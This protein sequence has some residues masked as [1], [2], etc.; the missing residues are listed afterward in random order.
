M[1]IP[2]CIIEE[3]PQME[4]SELEKY[5]SRVWN[6]LKEMKPGDDLDIGKV[7]KPET[8]ELFVE[9]CKHYMR[10]HEWQDGLTFRKGFVSL[11]KVAIH[12]SKTS[13]PIKQTIK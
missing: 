8:R 5:H 7:T 1:N 13:K 12:Y 9:C 10:E 2:A 6:L 3:A 4:L 11:Y